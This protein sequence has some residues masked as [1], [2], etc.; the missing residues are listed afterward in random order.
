[1]LRTRLGEVTRCSL[2]YATQSITQRLALRCLELE[3][4]PISTYTHCSNL[5]FL[6]IEFGST[7]LEAS[8]NDSVFIFKIRI[9]AH[10]TLHVLLRFSMKTS[11]SC[12]LF[13]CY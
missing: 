13:S 6:T 7:L 1:M 9:T 12:I 5:T 3:T 2:N 4:K 8:N 10:L 11:C